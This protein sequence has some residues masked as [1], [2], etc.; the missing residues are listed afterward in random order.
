[1]YT[2]LVLLLN[3]LQFDSKFDFITFDIWQKMI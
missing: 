1:M 2:I 3:D